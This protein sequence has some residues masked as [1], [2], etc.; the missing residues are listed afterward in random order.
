M[1][2]EI[3]KFRFKNLEESVVSS[4]KNVGRYEF[5]ELFDENLKGRELEKIEKI[6]ADAQKNNFEVLPIVKEYKEVKKQRKR[7]TEEKVKKEV[8]LQVMGIK[9]FAY[10]KAHKQGL[11]KGRR[12]IIE[13]NRDTVHE[14]LNY[15]KEMIE[16]VAR[17]K[18]IILTDQKKEIFQ[19]IKTLTKWIILRELKNDGNYV[20]RLLEKLVSELQTKNNILLK[21]NQK[22]FARMPEIIDYIKSNLG[23]LVNVRLDVNQTSNLPGMVLESDEGIIDGTLGQQ[24]RG[25]DKIF[26]SVRIEEDEE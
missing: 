16:E 24:F 12:E 25:L 8:D 14:N 1:E 21:V 9:D 7:E 26:E 13:Q 2:G 23:E 22:D 18:E 6:I 4:K 5:K 10:E 19:L 11:E 15:L 20:E 17:A 3:K